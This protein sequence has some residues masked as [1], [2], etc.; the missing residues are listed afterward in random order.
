MVYSHATMLDPGSNE[1]RLAQAL[2]RVS[3]TRSS[4]RAVRPHREIAYARSPGG[5]AG[6]W[7]FALAAGSLALVVVAVMTEPP[8]FVQVPPTASGSGR[9]PLRSPL[10]HRQPATGGQCGI[11][12]PLP[13]W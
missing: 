9:V 2:T 8:P 6:R 10:P 12:N 3:C 5:A 4:A 1:L 7:S 13:E 11:A